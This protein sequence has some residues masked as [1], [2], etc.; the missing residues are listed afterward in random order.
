MTTTITSLEGVSEAEWLALRH[1]Y[2]GSSEMPIV[3]GGGYSSGKTRWDIWRV[4]RRAQPPTENGDDDE[5]M[6]WGREMQAIIGRAV[7]RHK[8]WQIHEGKEYAHDPDTRMGATVDFTVTSGDGL[9]I[10]ESKNRDWLFWR[11]RYTEDE[12]WIYDRIQLAHQM[13]LYPA[14]TWGGIAVAVGGNE[15]RFYHHTRESLQDIMDAIAVEAAAF[16]ASVEA[17]EEPEIVGADIPAW[18]MDRGPIVDRDPPVD[19]TE[20]LPDVDQMI[21]DWQSAKEAASSYEKMA[22]GL[23]AQLLQALGDNATGLGR[24]KGLSQKEAMIEAAT[25]ERKAY[26]RV[27]LK[28]FDRKLDGDDSDADVIGMM[29]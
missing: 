7:A 11:D 6:W 2:L 28:A 13:L 29:P 21:A 9:G 27:T 24:V 12:A 4:K 20:A 15:L 1:R 8:G 3:L 17:G 25:V 22:K 26:K 16:W 14:A 5:R 19:L 18:V 23:Q 10:I